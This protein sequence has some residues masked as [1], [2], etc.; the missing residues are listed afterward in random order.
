MKKLIVIIIAVLLFCVPVFGDQMPIKVVSGATDVI[1]YFVMRDRTTDVLDTGITIANLEMYYIEDQAAMSADVFV[2]TLASPTNSHDDG[3]CIHV[4]QG[5]YRIDWPDAAFNGGIGKRA[6]L[7]V[8]DGDSGAFTE[9][10]LVELSPP[11]EAVLADTDHVINSL[12]IDADTGTALSL[13]S[14]GGNGHGFSSTGVG[15]GAGAALTGGGN[16]MTIAGDNNAAAVVFLGQGTGSALYAEG[17]AT[18]HGFEVAA[19]AGATGPFNA[20]DLTAGTAGYSVSGTFDIALLADIAGAI[21]TG[22]YGSGR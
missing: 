13:I 10:M 19:G 21:W 22:R 3:K 7:I 5:V 2:G 6:Q 12:T 14:Q 4:G 9:V 15:S 18:G 17:G 1:T 8:V 11:V 16:G 20:I